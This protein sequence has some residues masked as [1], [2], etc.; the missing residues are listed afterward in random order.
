MA[1]EIERVNMNI[2]RVEIATL[3]IE[4]LQ[5]RPHVGDVTPLDCSKHAVKPKSTAR[6]TA[7]ASKTGEKRNVEGQGL[8]D[9]PHYS[10]KA[11]H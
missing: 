1:T 9:K 5:A 10:K 7:S 3:K 2:Q 8:F 4:A 11:K 6:S